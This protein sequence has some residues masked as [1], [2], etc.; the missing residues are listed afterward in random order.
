MH[1]GRTAAFCS[2]RRS[3]SLVPACRLLAGGLAMT[4]LL[5]PRFGAPIGTIE[6]EYV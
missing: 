5:A 3:D 1:C 4:Y 2:R 6:V